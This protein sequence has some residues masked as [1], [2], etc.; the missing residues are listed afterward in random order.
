MSYGEKIVVDKGSEWS[1]LSFEH[2][3]EDKWSQ[4]VVTLIF[5]LPRMAYIS[6]ID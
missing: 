4:F 5:Y 2:N 3:E 6:F 1:H